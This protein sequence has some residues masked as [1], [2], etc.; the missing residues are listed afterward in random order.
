M[1]GGGG[2]S[3]GSRQRAGAVT[4][5]YSLV[6]E[7]G[8]AGYSGCVLELPT[9]FATAKNVAALTSKAKEAVLLYFE[10]SNA[11]GSPG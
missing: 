6:I 2:V 5:K 11:D 7:G 1:R 3:G 10:T 9:I 4:R 8:E